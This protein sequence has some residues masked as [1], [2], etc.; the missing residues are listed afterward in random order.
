MG[1]LGNRKIFSEI[2]N[3]YENTIVNCIAI[4]GFGLFLCT[5]N[6]FRF[7]S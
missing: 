7:L 5:T 6:P 3:N 2:T 4:S 1:M